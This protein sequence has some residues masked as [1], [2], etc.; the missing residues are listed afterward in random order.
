MGSRK[1][2][3]ARMITSTAA[4]GAV[5]LAGRVCVWTVEQTTKA[6]KL[7]AKQSAELTSVTMAGWRVL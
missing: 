6:L 2:L 3:C 7:G 5:Q 1:Q 4:I